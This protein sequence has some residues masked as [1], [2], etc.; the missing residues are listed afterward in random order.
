MW[1]DF[2]TFLAGV[3]PTATVLDP[4]GTPNNILSFAQGGSVQVDWSFS[5]A[6]TPILS[7]LT[8]TVS[9]YAD[10]VGPGANTLVGTPSSV[11]GTATLPS[12]PNPPF[13]YS[14][15]IPIVPSSLAVGAYRLTTLITT[16]VTATGASMPIAGFVDGPI[17]Q[18]RP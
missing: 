13:S 18:V 14:A 7:A 8:F 16:V 17:I 2:G 15:P 6:G 9:L 12:P 3:G 5:G 10:P 11:L 1:D 4:D